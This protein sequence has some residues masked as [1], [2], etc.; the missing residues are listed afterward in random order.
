MLRYLIAIAGFLLMTAAV[1][2]AP[3][4]VTGAGS[5]QT[6][7][8]SSTLVTVVL[9][10][11]LARDMNLT[12][13]SVEESLIRFRDED[14]T[15]VVY[16]V[17]D[18]AEVRVQQDRVDWVSSV[19]GSPLQREDVSG[20]VRKAAERA[21]QLFRENPQPQIQVLASE[22]A[23]SSGSS[24]AIAFLERAALSGD[25]TTAVRA[26]QSLYVLGRNPT[27][28]TLKAGVGSSDRETRGAAAHLAGLVGLESLRD[29]V[30]E[31]VK[32]PAPAV[33]RGA[34]LGCGYY[35]DKRAIPYLLRALNTNDASKADAAVFAL[36]RIGDGDVRREMH[37]RV[38]TASGSE[39]YHSVRVLY[40]LEDPL[41]VELL[42][43]ELRGTS[44]YS[45]QT[46][47]MLAE[48]DYWDA[49]VY[50][51]KFLDDSRETSPQAFEQRI[52]AA[53]LLL[54]K[55]YV[56]AKAHLR[57]ILAMDPNSIYI[58][59]KLNDEVAH[60][61]A[62]NALK[63]RLC[64]ELAVRAQ[65]DMLQLLLAAVDDQNP[66]VALLAGRAI[67]A[68]SN[69]DYRARLGELYMPRP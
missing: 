24:D 20:A 9:K 64:M 10:K 45:V 30:F 67:M 12:V 62:H 36:A 38:Q 37:T 19:S 41:G 57:E 55:G 21:E 26:R 63:A 33:F 32:D 49:N 44:P 29:T 34:A 68:V 2:G 40:L 7:E 3:V 16:Q 52:R 47:L 53:A 5:L 28:E 50:L 15:P 1:A 56:Q 31:L 25:N 35:K 13:S 42:R 4:R 11:S 60:F 51:R 43:G 6:L 8:G 65:P 54:S 27:G 22:V 23:G 46:A 58:R 59:G 39:W 14:G 18:I 61:A 48:D 69:A 66:A 17:E